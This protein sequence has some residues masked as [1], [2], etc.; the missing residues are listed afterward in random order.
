[1]RDRE[2]R[3]D[4]LVDEFVKSVE[5]YLGNIDKVMSYDYF[6]SDDM[7]KLAQIAYELSEFADSVADEF[8]EVCERS[9]RSAKKCG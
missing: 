1:M 6:N 2:D 5:C 4:D 9:R 8:D 3:L 7:R